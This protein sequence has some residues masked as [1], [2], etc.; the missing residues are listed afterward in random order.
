MTTRQSFFETTKLNNIWNK[1]ISWNGMT[2]ASVM[3]HNDRE[4]KVVSAGATFDEVKERN[5][6]P[7]AEFHTQQEL[8]EYVKELA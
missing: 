7:I 3:W 1:V 4:W 6:K 2:L 8:W 5:Y